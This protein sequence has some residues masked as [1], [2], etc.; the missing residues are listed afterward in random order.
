[1][2]MSRRAQSRRRISWRAKRASEQSVV[3]VRLQDDA[4]EVHA[5]KRRVLERED[6]IVKGAKCTVWPMLHPMV[7]SVDDP[8]LEVRAARM[9]G[10][11]R[12]ALLIGEP[13]I[14]AAGHVHSRA[15]LHQEY[16]RMQVFGDARGRMKSD[17]VPNPLHIRF[18]DSVASQKFTG[19]VGTVDLETKLT[20]TI[21]AL[22]LFVVSA[23][24]AE[25]GQISERG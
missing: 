17:G 6:I 15:C 19:G 2:T 25:D 13:V 23:G 14:A 3:P 9:G 24:G 20:V 8:D 1:M 18:R 4:A 12:L 10:D 22:P 16:L 5:V 11:D 21:L 7:E